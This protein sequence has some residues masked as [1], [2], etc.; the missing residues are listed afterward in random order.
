MGPLII[1]LTSKGQFTLPRRPREAL[2]IRPGDYVALTSTP[3]GVLISAAK[4]ATE[5]QPDE[6]LSQLVR[7]MGPHLEGL[8][9]DEEA[10][11]DEAIRVAKRE[12][13]ERRYG[14]PAT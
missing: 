3:D 6:I 10:Q 14:G 1:R 4:I 8:G 5:R 7:E 11:L 2:R 9:I 12:A 13:Y